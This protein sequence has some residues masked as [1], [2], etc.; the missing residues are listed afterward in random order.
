MKRKYSVSSG[1]KTGVE[2]R[3]YSG[4][5]EEKE[6]VIELY[7]EVFAEPPW[8]EEWT[9][10]EVERNI[11]DAINRNGTV[12]MAGDPELVGFAWGYPDPERAA[13]VGLGEGYFYIAE[14]AVQKDYRNKGVGTTLMME[15]ERY[16]VERYRTSGFFFRTLNEA[17]IAL[18]KKLGYRELGYAEQVRKER[19][20][21]EV[22][23]DRRV[24]F[25][26]EA[27]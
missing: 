3:E 7:R 14:V 25:F 12:L 5:P 21:G 26:K 6:E 10:E 18:G 22:Q 23:Q 4:T 2:I 24:Y 20:S 17:M 9:K 19:T 1:R 11:E 8:N 27:K 13:K 15:L 16:A